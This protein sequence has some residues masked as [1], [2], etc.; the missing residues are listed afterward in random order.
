MTRTLD[1]V[2]AGTVAGISSIL[3]CHPLDTIRTRL[4]V[5]SEYRGAWDCAIRLVREEGFTSLYRG[6]VGPVM[7]QGAYKAIMFGVYGF[8]SSRTSQSPLELFACGG[9]AGG[10]NA[11][12]LTPVELIR[13]RQQVSTKNFLQTMRE[14]KSLYRGLGATLCRDVPG[15]GA[16]YLTFEFLKRDFGNFVAGAAGG[17]SFWTIALPFDHVKSRLQVDPSLTLKEI[18]F[19]SPPLKDPLFS[20]LY[21]GYWSAL[22]RGIPGAAIVFTVYG[23]VLE[24]LV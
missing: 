13:N 23:F 12:V 16:Y 9:L 15:V 4:Q 21:V 2:L 10:A 11:V 3:V 5:S 14:A 24:R 22:A 19:P 7:A 18:L 6:M 17:F 1:H 8:A 20:R